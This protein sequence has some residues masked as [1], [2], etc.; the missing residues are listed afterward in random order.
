MK[1]D[2]DIIERTYCDCPECKLACKTMPGSLAPGDAKKIAEFMHRELDNKFLETYFDASDGTVVM[3][4]D[5]PMIVPTIVPKQRADGSCVFLTADCR[6]SVHRVAPYGCRN[7]TVCDHGGSDGEQGSKSATQVA[8]ILTE[9]KKEYLWHWGHLNSTGHVAL[10]AASRRG[11]F[12]EELKV[13]RACQ[14]YEC[15][16]RCDDE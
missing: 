2:L 14:Q 11:K 5:G 10:P 15:E 6:C 3:T 7:F 4:P 1:I 8:A 12:E 13:L 16:D 9:P